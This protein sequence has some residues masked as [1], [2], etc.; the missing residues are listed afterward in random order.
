MHSACPQEVGELPHSFLQLSSVGRAPPTL[1]P[2]PQLSWRITDSWKGGLQGDL[3]SSLL[4]VIIALTKV[5]HS[6]QITEF[7]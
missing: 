1:T 2:A 4:S 7:L 6:W 5:P 3:F